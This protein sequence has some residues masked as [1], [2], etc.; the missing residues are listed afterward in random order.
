VKENIEK[1]PKYGP[2]DGQGHGQGKGGISILDPAWESVND[3]VFAR[4]GILS[5]KVDVAEKQTEN[6]EKDQRWK[7]IEE[8]VL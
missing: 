8:H 4:F 2:G 7:Q 6:Q 5:M 3:S 1:G